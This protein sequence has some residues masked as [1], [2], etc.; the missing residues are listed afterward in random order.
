MRELHIEWTHEVEDEEADTVSGCLEEVVQIPAKHEVCSDCEGHGTVLN[1][2]MRHHAYSA[3]EFMR[4]FDDDERAEYFK[5]GGIYDVVCPTCGGKNV[6]KV[7]D[8]EAAWDSDPAKSESLKNAY[9][10][11]KQTEHEVEQEQCEEIR[12]EELMLGNYDYL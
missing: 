3:E 5:R 1:E 8:F 11:Q 12:R 10:K 2:S 7:P 9:R 6:E 4:E